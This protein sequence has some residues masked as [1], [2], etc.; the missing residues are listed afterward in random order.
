MSSYY[1]YIRDYTDTDEGYEFTIYE[2]G[3]F[4]TAIIDLTFVFSVSGQPMINDG[5]VLNEEEEMFF[6]DTVTDFYNYINNLSY[7][8]EWVIEGFGEYVSG[9]PVPLLQ[10]NRAQDLLN[11]V[12]NTTNESNEFESQELLNGL[13]QEALD[14]NAN[15]AVQINNFTPFYSTDPGVPII[16]KNDIKTNT[17]LTNLFGPT[18]IKPGIIRK[19]IIDNTKFTKKQ[20]LHSSIARLVKIPESN[21]YTYKIA[22]PTL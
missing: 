21:S 11:E 19:N 13:P 5:T 7:A 14:P 2:D 3:P 15:Y 8:Y 1:V 18:K 17:L 12:L 22:F 20:R 10:N 16:S 4:G 6:Y 9:I